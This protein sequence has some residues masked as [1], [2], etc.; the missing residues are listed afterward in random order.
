MDKFDYIERDTYHIG[1]LGIS[2]DYHRVFGNSNVID[3]HL[4]FST[5]VRI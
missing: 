1:L 3:D 4:G 5:K 2:V